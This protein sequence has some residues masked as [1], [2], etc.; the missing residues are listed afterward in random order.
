[1]MTSRTEY[2][3]TLRQ[4]NADERL[5][6]TGH[7]IGLVTDETYEKYKSKREKIEKE[8]ER[9]KNTV[10][11]PSEKL[12]SMLISLGEPP[13]T[14]GARLSDLLKRPP[15][16]YKTLASLIKM[17]TRKTSTAPRRP[18]RTG[19]RPAPPCTGRAT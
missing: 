18:R 16:D 10:L 19:T 11:P 15:V 17:P 6:E 1:M 9:L 2:R 8:E 3:L 13:V 12:N 5:C 7:D 4:D 14:T